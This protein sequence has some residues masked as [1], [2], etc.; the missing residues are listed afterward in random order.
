MEV[1]NLIGMRIS[2]QKNHHTIIIDTA[3]L[4]GKFGLLSG[5][6]G[7]MPGNTAH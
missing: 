4:K 1:K 7:S 6:V 3:S 2:Q 5:V